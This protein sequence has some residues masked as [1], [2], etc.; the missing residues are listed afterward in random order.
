MRCAKQNMKLDYAYIYHP[1]TNGQVEWANGMTLS[2]IK[3]LL[4]QS[5]EEADNKWAEQL[6]SMLWSL[7]TTPNRSTG[8]TPFFIVYDVEAILPSDLIHDA[9]RVRLYEEREAEQSC[10]DDLDA[11]DE[12]RDIAKA[13]SAFCQQQVHRY[14][15]QEVWVKAFIIDDL[16]L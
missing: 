14:L 5:L 12:E 16:G 6:N 3:P 1:Q 2:G 10:Q 8:Y 13:R 9:P 7:W 11:L 4:I 15:L